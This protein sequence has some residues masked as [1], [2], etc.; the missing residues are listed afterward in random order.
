MSVVSKWIVRS[1]AQRAINRFGGEWQFGEPDADGV[2]YGV[3]DGGGGPERA[4]FTDTLDAV[5][6]IVLR[7]IHRFLDYDGRQIEDAWALVVGERRI[8][9]L[10]GLALSFLFHGEPLLHYRGAG[11]LLLH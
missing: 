3:R 10:H 5:W 7:R 8:G 11:N 2:S 9:H 6:A 4:G 1:G